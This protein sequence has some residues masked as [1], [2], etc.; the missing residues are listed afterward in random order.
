MG[1]NS[2]CQNFNYIFIIQCY[3]FH[4]AF[5][6]RTLNYYAQILGVYVLNE[7]DCV[8]S[9]VARIWPVSIRRNVYFINTPPHSPRYAPR[10]RRHQRTSAPV[11]VRFEVADKL[12][13]V[14]LSHSARYWLGSIA[15]VFSVNFPD[16]TTGQRCCAGQA[17]PCVHGYQ[18]LKVRNEFQTRNLVKFTAGGH[19]E[20]IQFILQR[21][22]MQR[23][24]K[25]MKECQKK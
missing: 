14:F 20:R 13:V 6:F 12:L 9:L 22:I 2:C 7:R 4:Y 3:I 21:K 23:G 19:A 1:A 16:W 8:A 10:A 18:T 25:V 17:S 24:F 5:L 15:R 11:S